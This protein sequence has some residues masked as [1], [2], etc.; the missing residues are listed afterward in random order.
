MGAGTVRR[1]AHTL[2][3]DVLGGLIHRMPRT[4]FLFIFA[5]VAACGLPPLNAFVSEYIL[6]NAMLKGLNTNNVSVELLLLLALVT[7]VM[8]G[9]MAIYAFSQVVGVTFLG[10]PRSEQAANATQPDPFYRYPQYLLAAIIVSFGLFPGWYLNGFTA[11]AESVL[12]GATR[13]MIPAIPWLNDLGIAGMVFLGITGAIL[14][15]RF[16]RVKT[17]TVSYGA[18]WA[19]GYLALNTRMQYTA[20]GFADYL[21]TF[22]KALVG[23]AREYEP[24]PEIEIFPGKRKFEVASY[25]P[26]HR[27]IV[28]R[29]GFL[30]RFGLNKAA[31][32]QTGQIQSYILYAC[33]FIV[34]IFLLTLFNFI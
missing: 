30:V 23:M 10:M 1:K 19:C 17:N 25:D 33:L 26:L 3:M 8:V 18:P 7:L 9:G 29:I 13:T 27:K 24:I 15:I 21:T 16:S 4:A 34:A 12:P 20:T 2:N 22:A 31:I 6:Y 5:S 11:I 32:V 28:T 14:A